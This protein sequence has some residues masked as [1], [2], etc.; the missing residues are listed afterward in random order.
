MREQPISFYDPHEDATA[1]QP[2]AHQNISGY[3]REIPLEPQ[4]FI[5]E[6]CGASRIKFTYPPYAK[7]RWC[8]EACRSAGIRKYN[9]QK[10]R[11]QR[12]R[13][14]AGLAKESK[15]GRPRTHEHEKD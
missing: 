3:T 7:P 13:D 4:E 9:A 14:K 6:H 5:C 12:A 1:E 11:E 15:R 10:K 8:N 2:T